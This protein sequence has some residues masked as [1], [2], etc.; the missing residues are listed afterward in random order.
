MAESGIKHLRIYC[1]C[2]QKMK[3]AADMYGRP[4]KCVACRQKIRLPR[5]DEIPEGSTEIRIEDHPEFLRKS[6]RPLDPLA[7]EREARQA[8]ARAAPAADDSGEP[9]TPITELD[10]HDEQTPAREERPK[11]RKKKRKRARGSVPLDILPALRT[12][13][14]LQFKLEHKLE[15]S[16][17]AL[18]KDNFVI[19]EIEGDLARLYRVRG[20]LDEQLR[21]TLMEVAIELSSTHEKIGETN[22]SARVGEISYKVYHDK[23]FSL[24]GRRDRLERRQQNL[25]GWLSAKD[26]YVAGGYIDL[27][28][29]SLPEQN[30]TLKIPSE[31]EELDPILNVHV[32]TLRGALSR[33]DIATR[34]LTEMRALSQSKHAGS[35]DFKIVRANCK[36]DMRIA[37]ATVAFSRGRLRELK[38]DFESDIETIGAQLDIER[39]NL[40][41]GSIE[42]TEFD[43][44]EKE[45]FRAKTDTAKALSITDRALIASD[46]TE[47]P[48]L[49]G[50]F[51]ERL[52]TRRPEDRVGADSIM[53]WTAAALMVISVFL[54]AIGAISM[55]AAFSQSSADAGAARW[56]IVAP[57]ALA[58]ALALIGWVGDRPLRGRLLCIAWLVGTVAGAWFI[59]QAQFG[60]DPIS[61]RFRVGTPWIMRPGMLTLIV[62]CAGV[63]IAAGLALR[64]REQNRAWLS[65]TAALGLILALAIFTDLGGFLTADPSITVTRGAV[66]GDRD[67]VS[68]EHHTITIRNDGRRTLSLLG[69]ASEAR[70]AYLISV[71]RQIGKTSWDEVELPPSLEGGSSGP[72]KILRT[73]APGDSSDIAMN[74][75]P[76]SYR[77]YLRSEVADDVL[78]H[79]SVEEPPAP[80]TPVARVLPPVAVA[81]PTQPSAPT[82]DAPTVE[83]EMK[84]VLASPGTTTRFQFVLYL[85]DGTQ[86]Q[87]ML[88]VEDSLH[89]SWIVDEYNRNLGSVTLRS[90]TT[91]LIL[92]TGQRRKLELPTL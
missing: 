71:D 66:A 26:P 49:R 58:V 61:A 68:Y 39:G 7:E 41:S 91:R 38:S 33:Q 3:V 67:G 12:L 72:S 56:I 40:K 75:A 54:P 14:S 5:P 47:V 9:P 20:D 15:A 92:R 18:D 36:A 84:G 62:A 63:L 32:A 64:G 21:Q 11:P 55:V 45:L 90:G 77:V 59:H 27:D 35:R 29:D 17:K 22:L 13:C 19:A 4:G 65:A 52:T 34:K 51:L 86:K 87:T 8:L 88:S 30:Y 81:P 80:P 85:A 50:T 24:R 70:G 74:L 57:V 82:V 37:Q 2:G 73:I 42:R 78:E 23:V 53:A 83:V 48:H 6:K 16:I 89:G 31:P 1:I 79:F 10:L 60:L 76:G 25:R 69:R 28:L 43:T 44:I 46:A